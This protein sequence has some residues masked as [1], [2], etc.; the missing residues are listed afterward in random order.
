MDP[1]PVKLVRRMGCHYAIA[2]NA[3]AELAAQKMSERYPFNAIDIM[4]RCMFVMGHEIGQASAEQAA[5]VVFTPPLGDITLLQF[6]RSPEIIECGRKAAEENLPAILA[7][8]K[9]LADEVRGES[10]PAPAE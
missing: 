7:G 2:V 9:R 3:M 8:Y 1:I 6:S 4:T 10:P 5:D